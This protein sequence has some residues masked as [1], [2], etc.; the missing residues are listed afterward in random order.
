MKNL[1]SEIQ[2]NNDAK[3]KWCGTEGALAISTPKMGYSD[4]VTYW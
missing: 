4:Y 3:E 2:E 1:I